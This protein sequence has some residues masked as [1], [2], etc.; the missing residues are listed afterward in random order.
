MNFLRIS[1]VGL[2]F[3]LSAVAISAKEDAV[4]ESNRYFDRT[5]NPYHRGRA[6]GT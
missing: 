3:L 4:Q 1:V 2:A 5:S 6:T